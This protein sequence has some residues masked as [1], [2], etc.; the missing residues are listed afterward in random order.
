MTVGPP[1]R[2]DLEQVR[3]WRNLIPE[4][5]RTPFML[6]E[7]QQEHYYLQLCDRSAP[8]RMWCFYEAHELLGFGG[9]QGIQW[10]NGRAE[11]SLVL[12][13]A[14]RRKGWGTKIVDEI[15]RRAFQD[16]RLLTVVAEVYRC[17]PAIEFWERIAGGWGAK[18]TSLPRTKYWQGRLFDSLILTFVEPG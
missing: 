17:N 7:E 14:L 18:K 11:I 1:T 3:Q 16:L 5:L 12:N 15:L 6:T 4:A 8:V 2:E 13:P 10:E 9:L